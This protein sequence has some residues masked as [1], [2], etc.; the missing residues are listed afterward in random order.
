MQPASRSDESALW[1]LVL[2]GVPS[3]A[4]GAGLVPLVRR[5]LLP[6][7]LPR[8]DQLLEEARAIFKDALAQSL[9]AE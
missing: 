3:G 8:P 2:Q 7:V 4:V 5:E 9:S 6:L 1:L